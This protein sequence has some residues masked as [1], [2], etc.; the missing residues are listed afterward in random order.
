M[1]SSLAPSPPLRKRSPSSHVGTFKRSIIPFPATANISPNK[2]PGC[3]PLRQQMQLR[4]HPSLL[5][6]P[7]ITPPNLRLLPKPRGLGPAPSQTPACRPH[8][9]KRPRPAPRP[10]H[11]TA[12]GER[13]GRLQLPLPTAQALQHIPLAAVVHPLRLP[14]R[15]LCAGA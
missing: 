10:L 4:P 14:V 7:L 11:P 5:G 3:M 12:H 2:H 6:L 8:S 1:V 9:C 13:M 15:P